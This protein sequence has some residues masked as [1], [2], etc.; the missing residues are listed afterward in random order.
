LRKV[1]RARNGSGRPMPILLTRALAAALWLGAG[2]APAAMGADSPS[3]ICPDDS[4]LGGWIRAQH[5]DHVRRTEHDGCD[6]ETNVFVSFDLVSAGPDMAVLKAAQAADVARLPNLSSQARE[7]MWS[8]RLAAQGGVGRYATKLKYRIWTD[9]CHD[10]GGDLYTCNAPSARA[11]GE[12]ALGEHTPTGFKPIPDA[13]GVSTTELLFTPMAPSL[14]ISPG[15]R[16]DQDLLPQ[17]DGK[18]VENQRYSTATIGPINRRNI[19]YGG[20]ISIYIVPAPD[21]A[22]DNSP[23]N[24]ITFCTPPTACF[25]TTDQAQRRQCNT[26]P[27]KFAVLPFEGHAE[28]AVSN[29]EG[30]VFAKAS[31][32]VCCG[33]GQIG[34]THH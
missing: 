3:Q 16:A 27:G 34:G 5:L 17:A 2:L 14:Q 9:G 25:K 28:R 13:D 18:C 33:C 32:K 26:D 20:S 12:L 24:P 4:P 30:E 7:K 10:I 8:A 29:R 1:V 19:G 21:C 22:W 11:T 23:G 15:R 31:W 6:Q